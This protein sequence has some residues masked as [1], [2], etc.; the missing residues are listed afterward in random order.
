MIV[1]AIVL[2]VV[3]VGAVAYVVILR[4][5]HTKTLNTM[6]ET[7]TIPGSL[8]CDRYAGDRVQTKLVERLRGDA[9]LVD[10]AEERS[11]QLT[12]AVNAMDQGAVVVDA[13]ATVVFANQYA[14][15]FIDG[16]HGDALV[17]AKLNELISIALQGTEAEGEV[18]LFGP[19]RRTLALTARPLLA[20]DS[21]SATGAIVLIDD[22]TEARQVDA[23]RR[24]FVA[25]IGHELKTPIGAISL[26]AETLEGESDPA[27][28]E[29]FVTRIG[30]EAHRLSEAVD[31]LLQFS[32][33]E[34]D[35][36]GRRKQVTLEK[37]LDK[38]VERH[39]VAAE[40]KDISLVVDAP[41][42]LLE[43]WANQKQL[44]S[45]LSNLVDN[46]IKYSDD[47][48]SVTVRSW[49]D[50]EQVYFEVSDT[51]AGIPARDLDR[52]FERFY[53]VDAARERTTGGIGL[54]LAIV[55][56][57]ARNHG[58]EVT[59]T[60]VEGE[61][62]IFTLSIPLDLKEVQATS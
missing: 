31:D 49:Y 35:E 56:H 34:H 1:L 9:K 38:A 51:G 30:G 27:I 4:R 37:V 44:V 8:D 18:V 15:A 53:R 41:S 62:S 45:A 46:A 42:G 5:E 22:V 57:V 48:I 12:D 28:V 20:D 39:R 21:T 11:S 7:L 32:R 10:V 47:G 54:G 3:A 29:R 55:N 43:F 52:I 6:A 36:R 16:R 23:V 60:S 58:G 25:N 17:R 24:D 50:S 33:T 2:G 26:L 19:P 61:G 14:S 40:G 59:V 13:A